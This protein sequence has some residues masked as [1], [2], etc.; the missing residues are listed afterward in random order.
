[1]AACSLHG[2]ANWITVMP[3][4]A[5]ETWASISTVASP[6]KNGG[7]HAEVRVAGHRRVQLGAPLPHVHNVHLHID[8][9]KRGRILG[10]CKNSSRIGK[11]KRGSHIAAGRGAELKQQQ[12]EDEQRRHW[13]LRGLPGSPGKARRS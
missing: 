6:A 7:E 5:S 2:Q 13:S 11:P 10:D 1:L 9:K 12:E 4:R 3:I 8:A